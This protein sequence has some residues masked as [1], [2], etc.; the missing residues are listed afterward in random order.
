[1]SELDQGTLS[2]MVKLAMTARDNAYCPYSNHPVG[3]A[4]LSDTGVIY[5]G[6]NVESANYAGCCAENSA[7]AAMNTAGER[8]IKA[9][10]VSGPG[11]DYL[12]TPCGACRQ[13][14]REFAQ[15][16]TPIY[17][18]WKDGSVGK[19]STMDALLPDSFG[20]EH[21]VEVNAK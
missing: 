11:A 7:I 19:V 14:L 10:V 5:A 8:V 1:M 6:C 16:E 21:L 12:C 3:A 20:P 9:V 13:R 18:L 4:L 15:P 2:K 17:S